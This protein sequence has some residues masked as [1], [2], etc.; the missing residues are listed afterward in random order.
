MA[1]AVPKKAT[2]ISARP[3]IVLAP[4]PNPSK[5]S[6]A[7]QVEV[8]GNVSYDGIGGIVK[9]DTPGTGQSMAP[10]A[11]QEQDLVAF[12]AVEILCYEGDSSIWLTIARRGH[13]VRCAHSP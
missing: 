10:V 12:A 4:N 2:V 6:C 1:T 5:A 9:I 8:V 3:S 7:T 11:G 13:G